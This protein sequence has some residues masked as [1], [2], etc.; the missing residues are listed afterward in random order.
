MKPRAAYRVVVI[1]IVV[2]AAVLVVSLV[3]GSWLLAV[4]GA[5]NCASLAVQWRHLRARGVA[6][7]R[8]LPD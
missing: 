7:T 2:C 1:G 5:I 4:V 6:W 3:E 8:P